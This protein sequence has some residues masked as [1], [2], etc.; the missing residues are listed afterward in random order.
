MSDK[1]MI[2]SNDELNK[3]NITR[4]IVNLAKRGNAKKLADY[5]LINEKNDREIEE[6]CNLVVKYGLIPKN[7]KIFPDRVDITYP[8][9]QSGKVTTKSFTQAEVMG[10]ITA[11]IHRRIIMYENIKKTFFYYQ[12]GEGEFRPAYEFINQIVTET[13]DESNKIHNPR[14]VV[15]NQI[16]KKQ[17][18]SDD[19]S[20]ISDEKNDEIQNIYS[21]LMN[22]NFTTIAYMI[23]A[24]YQIYM[25]YI[26]SDYVASFDDMLKELIDSLKE[27]STDY[28]EEKEEEFLGYIGT[29][30]RKYNIFDDTLES[31]FGFKRLPDQSVIGVLEFVLGKDNIAKFIKLLPESVIERK[32]VVNYLINNGYITQDE[33]FSLVDKDIAFILYNE[34]PNNELL[35]Y[36]H[37]EDL[38]DLFL[39]DKI[40]EALFVRNTRLS[41]ILNSNISGSKK[42][43]VLTK[44]KNGR[45]YSSADTAS[46]WK[47]YEQ[48]AFDASDVI[49]LNDS[50]YMHINTVINNYYEQQK[51]KIRA[52]LD[53]SSKVSDGKLYSFFTPSIVWQ[54]LKNDLSDA[55]RTFYCNDLKKIYADNQRNIELNILDL[56]RAEHKDDEVLYENECMRLYKEGF[57]SADTL[58]KANVSEKNCVKYYDKFGCKDDTLIDFYNNGLVSQDTVYEILGDN[59]DTKV[60]DLI[61]SGMEASVIQGLYSTLELIKKA[62]YGVISFENLAVIKDD[63]KTGIGQ[64]KNEKTLMDMYMNDEL[65]YTEL[66]SLA[67]AGIISKAE[68][69]TID[70]EYNEKKGLEELIGKGLKGRSVDYL[71]GVH[72]YD[73]LTMNNGKKD[74]SSGKVK[75]LAPIG[76]DR[77]LIISL[78]KRL[79]VSQIKQIDSEKCPVFEGYSLIPIPSMKV[80]VLEGLDGT[81]TYIA[82][83]K[84]ILEQINNPGSELDLV[85]NATSRNQFNRNK[86]YIESVNHTKNWG[87]N[88]IKKISRVGHT[89]TTTDVNRLIKSNED[90]LDEIEMTYSDMKSK[91]RLD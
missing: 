84:I 91:S 62:R 27:K 5:I 56:I 61:N 40:S 34:N 90:I 55:E 22:C 3:K 33:L 73:G 79:G 28:T 10:Y 31:C 72:S 58:S 76:I 8:D 59:F 87:K 20:E 35:K 67:E 68:A 88:L 30:A 15:I 44:G 12:Y 23:S 63:I 89:L 21:G 37:K 1:L 39:E 45:L 9:E 69:D 74:K 41:D 53:M 60:V 19:N 26:D 75:S 29:C 49:A 52:E 46:I 42:M 43:K 77:D 24:C 71:Y 66:Y 11:D 50:R 13:R 85:G 17:G 54:Q 83:I 2:F 78:Y 36:L 57:F 38:I 7:V 25:N 32:N 64:G 4:N 70:D 81:R 6:D 51:H 14:K 82:P 48:D 86:K 47:L 80:C 16:E 65:S 18:G